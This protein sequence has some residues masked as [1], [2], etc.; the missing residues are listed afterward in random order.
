[1]PAS[2][3][4]RSSRLGPLGRRK[5]TFLLVSVQIPIDSGEIIILPPLLYVFKPGKKRRKP[6]NAIQAP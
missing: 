2:K 1:M 6:E 5:L 4:N 3:I